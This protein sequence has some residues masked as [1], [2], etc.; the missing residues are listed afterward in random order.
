L[1]VLTGIDCNKKQI[2][3]TNPNIISRE[4]C[5]LQLSGRAHI[6]NWCSHLAVLSNDRSASITCACLRIFILSLGNRLL[7]AAVLWLARLPWFQQLP[8]DASRRFRLGRRVWLAAQP[9]FLAL[10][11]KQNNFPLIAYLCSCLV[12]NYYCCYS[13]FL[14]NTSLHTMTN[15]TWQASIHILMLLNFDKSGLYQANA[16][17]AIS[18]YSS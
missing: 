16:S 3:A 13:P 17:T 8:Y 10:R 12:F 1:Y 14:I 5:Q 2:T 4:C 18:R 6:A 7:R 11:L 15:V 9:G